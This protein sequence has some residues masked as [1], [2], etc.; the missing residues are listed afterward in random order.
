MRERGIPLLSLTLFATL[1]DPGEDFTE[2]CDELG[3]PVHVDNP[4][5]KA[6]KSGLAR[7]KRSIKKTFKGK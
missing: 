5:M 7:V 6:G 1:F 2:L 4:E 3:L